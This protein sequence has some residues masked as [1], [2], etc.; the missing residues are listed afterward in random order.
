MKM[1]CVQV[2]QSVRRNRIVSCLAKMKKYAA[3]DNW[4]D[5]SLHSR[6]HEY[7]FG[8]VNALLTV[9]RAFGNLAGSPISLQ[10]KT[11]EEVKG[12][13][14]THGKGFDDDEIDT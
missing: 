2:R 12:S 7:L 13:S 11:M 6:S 3:C 9:P 8:V 1:N 5:H 4:M 14:S 10:L